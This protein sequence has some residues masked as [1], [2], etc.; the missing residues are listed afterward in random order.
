MRNFGVEIVQNVRF[1]KV[2]EQQPR[3][4][5]MGSF[6]NSTLQTVSD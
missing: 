5:R 3:K 4:W 2:C 1:V 6:A